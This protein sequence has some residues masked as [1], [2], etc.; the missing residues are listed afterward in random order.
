MES[1][2]VRA[3]ASGDVPAIAELHVAAW[4]AA[5]RGLMPDEYLASLSVAQRSEMWSRALSRAGPTHLVVA[6]LG[7]SVAGFCFFGPSRDAGNDVAEI[8][9]VNVHPERWRLGAGRALCQH[10][11]RQASTRECAAVTLWVLK[12]NE[13]ARRFYERLGYAV[14][15]GERTETRLIG[16]PLQ[17]LR[18]RKA[19]A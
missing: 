1:L 16:S 12:A 11:L 17:E 3:A 18:Y 6:E 10:A 15:G 5:Y 19:I 4:R 14:D 2:T 7:G 8:F 9:A 13:P